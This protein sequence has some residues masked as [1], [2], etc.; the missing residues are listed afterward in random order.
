[1]THNAL[2]PVASCFIDTFLARVVSTWVVKTFID[3]LALVR[4]ESRDL[5]VSWVTYAAGLCLVT[6]SM[7]STVAT[8]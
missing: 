1:M 6:A 7:F 8:C 3:I 2:T 4:V 5:L